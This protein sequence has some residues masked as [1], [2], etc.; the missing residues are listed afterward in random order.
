MSLVT[1]TSDN[2]EAEVKNSDIPVL[3]DFWAAWC[4]P[5]R[6]LSPIIE[7]LAD[8]L[9]DVKIAKLDVDAFPAIAMEYG[10]MSIPTLILFEHGDVAKKSMGAVPKNS[11]LEMLDK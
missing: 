11:I 7:E 3:V 2:F 8:E 5:C 4:G 10:V 9:S 6:M 1:L